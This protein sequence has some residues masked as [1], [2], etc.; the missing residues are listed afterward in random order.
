MSGR[1]LFFYFWVVFQDN[2]TL[3]FPVVVSYF[4]AVSGNSSTAMMVLVLLSDKRNRGD[5]CQFISG[6]QS[7][8]IAK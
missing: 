2:V 1:L 8:I 6:E 4:T 5:G 3:L 7:W